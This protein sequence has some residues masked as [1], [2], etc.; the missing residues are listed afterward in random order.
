MFQKTK[1]PKYKVIVVKMNDAVNTSHTGKFKE[2]LD[3]VMNAKEEELASE[4]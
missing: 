2:T 3:L 1:K 4:K